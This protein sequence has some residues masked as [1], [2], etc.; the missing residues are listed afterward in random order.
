MSLEANKALMRRFYEEFWCR[1]NAE[2][3]DEL[4]TPDFVDH[5]LPRGWPAGPEGLKRLVREWRTG[6][7]DMHEDVEDLIAEGDRVAGRFVI[8]GTHK[9]SFMGLA[10]TGRSVRLTGID[11][12][13]VRDGRIAEWWYSEDAM[14]LLRQL[15]RIP[16]ETAW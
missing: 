12:V 11:I 10:A 1:G 9:G 6:F 14:G 7:P 16:D 13:R 2:A 3:V 4:V 15:G 5:Q 8:T